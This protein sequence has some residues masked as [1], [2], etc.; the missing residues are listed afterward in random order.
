M[1]IIVNAAALRSGG[2][3]SIY[4]QFIFHLSRRVDGNRYYI[5]VDSS[6]NQPLIEGVTYIH[7]SNHSWRHRILW[8]HGGLN[9]WLRASGLVPDVIV[10]LQNTGVV[11]DFR[12]VIYYHQSLPFFTHKWNLF[13]SS[14]RILWSYKHVYPYFVKSTLNAKT[15]VVVQIPFIKREFIRKFNI[16]PEH[17][18]VCFPDVERIN[19]EFV[20][21]KKWDGGFIHFLYPATSFS[22]K[23]HQTILEA[24]NILKKRKS[25]VADKIRIHLTI[26][27][28]DSN[29]ID[30]MVDRYGL[31]EQIMFE[32]QLPHETL[33]SYYKSSQGL[34]FPSIIETLG[35][36]MLEAAS[37]GLPI[38]AS[39][40]DY[41]REVL[42]GYSGVNFINAFDYQLWAN[43]I[44]QVCLYPG[45]YDALPPKESSWDR[46]FKLIVGN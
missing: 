42:M 45:K 28:G 8:E 25:T 17:V 26:S 35:L 43:A 27:K 16:S 37:F 21:E 39:D 3:L 2:A 12:Q 23:R 31:Q 30:R 15:D 40:L 18:H 1:N 29:L 44:E 6:A 46:F 24:L 14:E 22:Y 7:D 13:S 33:L 41:A 19:A 11:T 20:Q 5:F 34:L 38:I 10:S 32:G 36:P 4:N 9:K